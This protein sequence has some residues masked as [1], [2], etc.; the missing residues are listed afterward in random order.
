LHIALCCPAWPTN[1]SAS[2][3][4]TYVHNL[5]IELLAQ[6][7]RVSVFAGRI[8]STNSDAQ[9]YRIAP[10]PKHG[11]LTRLRR[12]VRRQPFS[13]SVW[14]RHIAD[15]VN[16]VHQGDPIDILEMEESFGWC[17][18]VQKLVP[19][20]VVVKLHGPA[21][22][23]L[24]GE[25]R[26]TPFAR[27][28]LRTEKLGMQQMNVIMSPSR[29]ALHETICQYGLKPTIQRVI[30]NPVTVAKDMPTWD[31]D[32]C[33]RRTILFVGR[34]DKLKGG[35]IILLAFRQLL[36]WYPSLKLIFVGPDRGL[37]S[38]EGPPLFFDQFRD[39]QFSVGQRAS[40]SYLGELPKS[41]VMALRKQAM[42]TVVASRWENQP[43]T[44]LE[45]MIQGCPVVATNVGG[46]GEIIEN[47]VTGLL[48]KGGDVDDLCRAIKY[49][50]DNPDRAQQMGKNANRFVLTYHAAD[51]LAKETVDLYHQ[52]ISLA[53]TGAR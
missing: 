36:A 24:I 31:L 2:G 43:N 25:L 8:G 50:L 17:A 4:V 29:S 28:R 21:C 49:L 38:T 22:L 13:F 20:P 7:H 51:R 46:T 14:G 5:R 40:I 1:E 3:I 19:V 10:L 32:E 47:G 12:L 6:G 53:K 37:V 52:A 33:D 35:D 26:D 30:P 11:L 34:F 27:A 23:T 16:E 45:A 41:T 44:V 48:A 15:I 18:E 39:T 42:L 9:I